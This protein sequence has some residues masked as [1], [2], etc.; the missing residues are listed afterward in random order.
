MHVCRVNQG[1]NESALLLRVRLWFS[2]TA[3]LR[4]ANLCV[5]A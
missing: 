1:S 5:G 3:E 4:E 2:T